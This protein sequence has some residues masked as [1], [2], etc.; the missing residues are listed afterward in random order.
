[1]SKHILLLE[2]DLELARLMQDCIAAEGYTVSHAYT[3]A[4][5][6]QLI[7]QQ[8]FDLVICDVMLPGKSG[9]SL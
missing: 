5:A 3:A 9:F 7:H 6:A 2:D 4:R 8:T 1:M